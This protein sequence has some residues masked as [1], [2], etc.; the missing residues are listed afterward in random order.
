LL[1]ALERHLGHGAGRRFHLRDRELAPPPGGDRDSREERGE[2]PGP[3]KNARAALL[4][5][6]RQQAGLEAVFGAG[7]VGR[8]GAGGAEERL[9][10]GSRL[11]F[12][13]GLQDFS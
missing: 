13:A 5:Q 6:T 7:S 2:L 8:I 4:A 1:V 10:L 12:M 11:S 9:E 3:R